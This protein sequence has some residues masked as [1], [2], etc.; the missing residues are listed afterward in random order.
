MGRIMIAV[1]EDTLL[2]IEKLITEANEHQ[3]N[4]IAADILD[5]IQHVLTNGLNV[6]R[7]VE[8]RIKEEQETLHEIKLV[9]SKMSRDSKESLME[10][11]QNKLQ[12]Y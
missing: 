2:E 6:T 5:I 7:E 11:L 8:K 3:A 4:P 1:E 12:E 10:H 9:V